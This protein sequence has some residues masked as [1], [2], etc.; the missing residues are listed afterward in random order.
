VNLGS[1]DFSFSCVGRGV[2]RF[3]E[4]RYRKPRSNSGVFIDFCAL[5]GILGV[6]IICDVVWLW[7]VWVWVVVLVGIGWLVCSMLLYYIIIIPL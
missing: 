5:S 4:A 6:D 3:W 7:W 2:L 1:G